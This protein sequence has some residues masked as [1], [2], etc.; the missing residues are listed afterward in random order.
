MGVGLCDDA[1]NGGVWLYAMAF[2]QVEVQPH[3][4]PAAQGGQ[5]P[6]RFAPA[7]RGGH[8]AGGGQAALLGQLLHGGIDSGVQRVV[9]CAQH[10]GAAHAALLAKAQNLAATKVTTATI[11]STANRLHR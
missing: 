6:R 9:V 3:V 2:G 10:N 1:A 11:S 4:Q 8:A 5:G 7:W